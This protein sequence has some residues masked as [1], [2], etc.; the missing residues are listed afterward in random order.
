MKPVMFAIV[1]AVLAIE[2][3]C[4]N[5]KDFSHLIG[6]YRPPLCR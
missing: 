1:F 4:E 5:E 3:I 2:A 6:K